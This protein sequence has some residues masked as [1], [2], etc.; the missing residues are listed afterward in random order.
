MYSAGS[1]RRRRAGSTNSSPGTGFR[2]RGSIKP[3]RLARPRPIHPKRPRRSNSS[4]VPLRSSADG[5]NLRERTCQVRNRVRQS[6]TLGSVGG[7]ARQR[8]LLPG[9]SASRRRRS[10]RR[11]AA[12]PASTCWPCSC[13]RGT[14]SP[15]RRTASEILLNDL[16]L[17]GGAIMVRCLAAG[18][19]PSNARQ[20]GQIIS[21]H[22][23]DLGGYSKSG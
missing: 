1:R 10:T 20:A 15:S 11:H 21:S 4:C 3:H 13:S 6:R 23:S 14:A 18:V 12:G 17:E 8:L 16:A 2:S 5:Y 19:E 9:R 22:L 7:G